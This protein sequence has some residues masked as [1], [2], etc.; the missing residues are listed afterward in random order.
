MLK[1]PL[2]SYC[3]ESELNFLYIN[4]REDFKSPTLRG[5]V[6]VQRRDV[7]IWMQIV[8]CPINYGP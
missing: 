8:V 5:T 1:F 3:L 6:T 2:L 4:S 7:I